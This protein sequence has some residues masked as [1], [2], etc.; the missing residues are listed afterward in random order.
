MKVVGVFRVHAY[1]DDNKMSL[2]NLATVFGPTLL[3][4]AAT[5]PDSAKKDSQKHGES[6]ATGTVDVMA[7]AGILYCYLQDLNG[8][9][10]NIRR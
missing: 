9:Q 4:P 6:L 7:Q 3:R 10:K 1:E 5:K 2:H 8:S